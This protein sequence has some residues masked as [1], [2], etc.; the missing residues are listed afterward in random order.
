MMSGTALTGCVRAV[1]LI[2]MMFFGIHY[3]TTSVLLFPERLSTK[4][5]FSVGS[6]TLTA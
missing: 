3:F 5:S 2:E 1:L 6:K 4:A